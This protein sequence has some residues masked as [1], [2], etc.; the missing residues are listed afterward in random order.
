[1]CVRLF[2]HKD[3]TRIGSPAVTAFVLDTISPCSEY[4]AVPFFLSHRRRLL[5]ASVRPAKDVESPSGFP[6]SLA[7]VDVNP[8]EVNVDAAGAP[9]RGKKSSED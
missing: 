3:W 6:E 9:G 7:L 2:I 5:L 4:E 1:M 8:A